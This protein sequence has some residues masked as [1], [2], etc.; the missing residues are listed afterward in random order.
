[1]RIAKKFFCKLC[2]HPIMCD[3]YP[4]VKAVTFDT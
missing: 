4:L 1:V 2:P 3:P